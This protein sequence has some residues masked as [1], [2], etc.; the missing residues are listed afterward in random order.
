LV[1]AGAR[2]LDVRALGELAAGH[3]PGAVNIPVQQLDARLSGLG[4]DQPGNHSLSIDLVST[5]EGI[6]VALSKVFDARAAIALSTL[7]DT[8]RA[9][10]PDWL[11]DEI[12]DLTF[13]G[14]PKPNLLIPRRAACAADRKPVSRR[15]V[16][17]EAGTVHGVVGAGRDEFA[18]AG[19]CLG[20][21]R[22]PTTD[23]DFTSDWVEV[24]ACE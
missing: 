14:D 1:N 22:R 24:L 12:F 19:Q 17:V 7:S 2:P 11:S 16:E 18:T 10:L 4:D 20:Q 5:S 6:R 15:L 13:G 21:T 23:L 3:I 8:L 9:D